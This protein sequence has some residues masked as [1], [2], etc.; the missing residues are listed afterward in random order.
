MTQQPTVASEWHSSHSEH[1]KAIFEYLKHLSTLTTG[2]ILLITTFLEKLFKSPQ[3]PWLVGLAVGS[4]FLCL[5]SCT[6][7]Y[8]VLLSKFP[9]ND[10]VLTASSLSRLE[11]FL[12]AGGMWVAWFTLLLGIGAIALFFLVKWFDR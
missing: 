6:A 11:I 7:T 10:R 8:S 3:W 9:R 1:A 12:Y 4:L 2:S 5:V